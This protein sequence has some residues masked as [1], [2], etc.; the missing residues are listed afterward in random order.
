MELGRVYTDS[1]LPPLL[2]LGV[3]LPWAGSLVVREGVDGVFAGGFPGG[4]DCPEDRAYEGDSGSP[5]APVGGDGEGQRGEAV[6]EDHLQNFSEKDAHNDAGD[7][8]DDGFAQHDVDNVGLGGAQGFENAD[9]ARAFQHSGVHGLED[10]EE[11][12]DHGNPDH[13]AQGDVE[14]GE[15]FGCHERHPFLDGLDLVE[16]E[17]RRGLDFLA[18]QLLVLKVITFDI[19]S[20]SIVGIAYQRSESTNG[21]ENSASLAVLDDA[22][23]AEGM[24]HDLDCGSK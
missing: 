3:S 9:F 5:N 21:Q 6:A 10:D 18:D 16:A 7:S 20:R 15:V 11:T 1:P 12:D 14:A 8:D 13:G 19:E 24:I 22:A 23:D 17:A 4:I 2:F